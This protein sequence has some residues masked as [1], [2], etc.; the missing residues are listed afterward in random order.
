MRLCLSSGPGGS[1]HRRRCARWHA[2]SKSG[3]DGM[4]AQGGKGDADQGLRRDQ[5]ADQSVCHGAFPGYH[6]VSVLQA[7]PI[8]D[9][10]VLMKGVLPEGRERRSEVFQTMTAARPQKQDPSLS[11]RISTHGWSASCRW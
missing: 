8:A 4:Q 5:A 11:Q 9:R 2:L 6:Y 10:T 7:R 1:I 3:S